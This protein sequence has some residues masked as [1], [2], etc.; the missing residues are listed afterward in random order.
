[1]V[2][3]VYKEA[4]CVRLISWKRI[5]LY[6]GTTSCGT[7]C[8]SRTDRCL[9][10]PVNALENKKFARR[11]NIGFHDNALGLEILDQR[12]YVPLC[13]AKLRDDGIAVNSFDA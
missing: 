7:C 13:P 1:M 10:D 3:V 11:L 12:A 4:K 6:R 9:A 2:Q 8:D 5:V